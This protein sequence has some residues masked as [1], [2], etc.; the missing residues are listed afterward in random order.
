MGTFRPDDADRTV[1]VRGRRSPPAPPGRRAPWLWWGVVLCLAPEEVGRWGDMGSPTARK[2]FTDFVGYLSQ[3][4]GQDLAP[5][6]RTWGF[7]LP[8]RG[9]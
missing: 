1:V 6:F 9:G 2:A 4:C 3:A 8:E 5:L 7:D